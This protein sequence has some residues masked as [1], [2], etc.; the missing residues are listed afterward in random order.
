MRAQPGIR[1]IIILVVA[2]GATQ[3]AFHPV[4][5]NGRVPVF[6][7]PVLQI[8]LGLDLQGGS[9]LVFEGRD[10]PT[11]KVTPDA[12]DAAMRVIEKRVDQLGVVEPTIQ[13]QG[14]NRVIVELPGIQ[15]PQRAINLIGK[16]ALLEFVDTGTQGL[17][18]GARWSPDGKTVTLPGGASSQQGQPRTVTLQKKVIITGADLETAQA[19]FD[20]QSS[21]PVVSF[22]LR[23]PG[24]KK[25]ENHTTANVNKYLTI[26]LDNEVISSPV[27]RGPI[28]GGSG[29]ISGGF[30]TIEEARDL[31]V[32]LRGGALPIPMQVVENRTVGPQLGRDS[33]DSSLRASWVA[34]TAVG[35]FM[36]LFYQLAGGLAVLALGLYMLLTLAALALI[37][38]TLTLPGIVGLVLSVGLAVDANVIIFEKMKEELRSGKTL[39]AAIEAGWHRALNAIID[40]NVTAVIAAAIL[41]F[42][43]SGPI[44]GFAV[45]LSVGV[46]ISMFTA[47]TV[48]RAFVDGAARIGLGPM[49]VRVAGKVS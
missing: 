3:I 35:L 10:T 9:L 33:I 16:T 30:Q 46:M 12:V 19:E 1:L 24:A 22:K 31:A 14:T 15:D 5:F 6:N 7:R 40:S 26:V 32:L 17:P 45:T 4:G 23:G 29:Q 37:G 13:R 28:G 36:T 2:L 25:F 43:G 47:I 20:Q 27:I 18:E 48:T 41:F 34:L 11:T 39:R 42:L 38:A 44:R 8:T 21:E 49:L